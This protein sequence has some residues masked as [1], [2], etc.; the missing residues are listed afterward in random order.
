MEAQF[1]RLSQAQVLAS[2][3]CD[4]G[5]GA[6]SLRSLKYVVINNDFFV[7]QPLLVKLS[8]RRKPRQ[9]L[10]AAANFRTASFTRCQHAAGCEPLVGFA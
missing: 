4:N 3:K 7:R 6:T 8:V 5:I 10:G 1:A 9:L 2:T